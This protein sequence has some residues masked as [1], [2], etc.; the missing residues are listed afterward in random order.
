MLSALNKKPNLLLLLFVATLIYCAGFTAIASEKTTKHSVHE[1]T[2]NIV[3]SDN[4]S[5]IGLHREPE[6]QL[7]T[8]SPNH[9][10]LIISLA[11]TVSCSLLVYLLVR[12]K[13][14]RERF[15]EGYITETRLAQKVHDEIANELYGTINYLS[16]E[17]EITGEAKEKLIAKLDD[18]YLMTKNISRET[19][20]IDTGSEY[21]EHLKMMLASYAGD[22]IN[23]IIKGLSDIN[24]DEV[25][26]TKKIATHRSLQELMVNMKKHSGASMVI[27]G[28]GLN[29]K[30]LEITYSDNGRGASKDQLLTKN[31]LQNIETRKASIDGQANLETD[32]EKGFC[33]TLHYP[34]HTS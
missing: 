1:K 31:G 25:D 13:H 14:K 24:W 7:N 29:G 33:V 19:N 15:M 32:P 8:T 3:T 23:V 12:A 17:K 22:T 30:K 21:P 10:L 18:I 2:G 6:P 28:F 9:K 26:D 4:A 20:N 5:A 16:S 27:I 34:A 11:F